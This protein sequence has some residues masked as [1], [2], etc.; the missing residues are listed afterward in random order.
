M[1]CKDEDFALLIWIQIL[2]QWLQLSWIVF[3]EWKKNSF[4]NNIKKIHYIFYPN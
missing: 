2:F 4:D 3:Q 1:Q